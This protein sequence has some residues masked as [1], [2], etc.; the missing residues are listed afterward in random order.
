ML[1]GVQNG[2]QSNVFR[3]G[4]NYR[5]LRF[6]VRLFCVDF[7]VYFVARYRPEYGRTGFHPLR[8]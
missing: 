1:T 7:P 8:P 4:V 2:F 6:S 5:F 3:L